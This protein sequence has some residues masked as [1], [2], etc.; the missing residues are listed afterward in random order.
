MYCGNLCTIGRLEDLSIDTAFC[1]TESM[2]SGTAL[3]NIIEGQRFGE[4][5]G[6]LEW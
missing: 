1:L 6:E 5:S 3:T 4:R 2:N